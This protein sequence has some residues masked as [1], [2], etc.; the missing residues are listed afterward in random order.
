[1]A[2]GHYLIKEPPIP[3]LEEAQ[4]AK[5]RWLRSKWQTWAHTHQTELRAMLHAKSDDKAAFKA[6]WD[7]LP[8]HATESE[9]G[10]GAADLLPPDHK[11]VPSTEWIA[12]GEA[13][14]SWAPVAKIG[15]KP[16]DGAM[17][18]RIQ[19]DYERGVQQDFAKMHDVHL[20]TALGG[21][22]QITLWA[23]GR[24][25]TKEA[26]LNP[27]LSPGQQVWLQRTYTEVQPPYDFLNKE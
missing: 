23:S 11:S 6:V 26:V 16:Q 10:F 15:T 4:F 12:H 5:I 9:L 17:A 20:S 7:V 8:A 3:G 2:P 24:V 19:R 25:T 22:K 27:N 1:M 18:N 14:L 13:V 21:S